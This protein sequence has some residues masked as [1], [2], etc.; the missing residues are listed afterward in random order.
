M[1]SPNNSLKDSPVNISQYQSSLLEDIGN[2][3]IER[4]V[5]FYEKNQI[6]KRLK[7]NLFSFFLISLWTFRFNNAIKYSCH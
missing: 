4:K 5:Q 1:L 3:E 2:A 7:K 6:Y